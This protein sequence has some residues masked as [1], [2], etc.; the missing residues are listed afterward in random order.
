MRSAYMR[1]SL[2]LCLGTASL[3][4]QEHQ[5][6][7]M[8]S[9]PEGKTEPGA[10]HHTDAEMQGMF[11]RYPMTREASGTSWQ[12]EASPMQGIH[13]S[14]GD[15]MFMAHGFAYAV[16]T[17]Q[18]GGRGDE[19][20]FSPNMLMLM[21]ELPLGNGTFGL[22]AMLSLEPATIGW[23]GYPELLQTGETA[24]GMTALID[25]QHPHDLF[26]ELAASYSLNLG[27][28]SSAF[29]YFGYPGEPALGPATFM[30]RFSGM[31][32]PEAPLSHH[33]LDS[34]H[35]T[36]GVVTLGYVW[37]DFKLDASL[38]TGRE[39]DQKRWNFDDARFD[40]YSV[41]LSWNP[42]KAW[43][44]QVSYG[45]LNSPEQ[46]HPEIDTERI[47]ASISYHHAWERKHWQTTLAWGRNIN[48]PG[49]SSDAGL[50]ESV[51][52]LDEKHT[53]F[54]RGEIMKKEE[55]F[56]SGDP[57]EHEQFTIGKLALGYIY[58]FTKF[59][60]IKLGI[61]GMAGIHFVPSSL[62]SSYGDTPTSYLLFLRAKL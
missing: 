6:G 38:F 54:G 48:D 20:V 4:A 50:L 52:T 8:S 14:S 58:D 42:S 32:N 40:S 22:R 59:H 11:G 49:E 15:W 19:D 21:G 44:M 13:F 12:P 55:L 26:M 53:L 25:R 60:G 10:A 7:P 5:H 41:R 24:D 33:W 31:D 35:I 27:A 39:P 57:Q 47:T 51:F 23:E 17:H 16:Y 3:G 56:P 1:T 62:E 61:G 28:D 45:A 37:R 36:F 43:S 18:E 2:S 29:V 9:P 30:H 34:T 46:L